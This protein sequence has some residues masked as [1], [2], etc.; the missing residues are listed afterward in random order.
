[1]Y[2]GGPTGPLGP[3]PPGAP[4]GP[5]YPGGPAGPGAPS[6]LGYFGGPKVKILLN[7]KNK[8]FSILIYLCRERQGIHLC[9][10]H[11]LTQEVLVHLIENV[12]TNRIKIGLPT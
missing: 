10:E 12:K 5:V 3:G 8:I 2:P 4:A 7:H 9:Q 6:G 11:R 1:V